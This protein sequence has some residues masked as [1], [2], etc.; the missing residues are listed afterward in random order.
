MYFYGVEDREKVYVHCKD[1]SAFI[2]YQ[3]DNPDRSCEQIVD[4]YF[5][6]GRW[7]CLIVVTDDASANLLHQPILESI[8]THRE[9]WGMELQLMEDSDDTDQGEDKEENDF[10]G[11]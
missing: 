3:K 8:N 10:Y 9:L 7:P 6:R 1:Y 11:M 5:L 2:K 4:E